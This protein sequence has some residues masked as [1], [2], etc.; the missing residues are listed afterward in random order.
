MAAAFRCT[1]VRVTIRPALGRGLRGDVLGK[2]RQRITAIILLGV[3]DITREGARRYSCQSGVWCAQG[4]SGGL[5]VGQKWQGAARSAG[6][7]YTNSTGKPIEVAVSVTSCINCGKFYYV[8]IDNAFR[9]SVSGFYQQA[10]TTF[11]VPNGQNYLI[12]IV[13]G[14]IA[15]WQEL[16]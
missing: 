16:R 1:D 5:G 2:C 11:I 12:S 9:Y 4:S 13:Y 15:Y 7:W 3:Q 10:A 6:V 8:Y 14:S